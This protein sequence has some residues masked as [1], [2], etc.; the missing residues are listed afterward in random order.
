MR[1]NNMQKSEDHLNGRKKGKRFLN[2]MANSVLN[3]VLP[4][5]SKFII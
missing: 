5:I 4:K 2:G 3:V 1:R